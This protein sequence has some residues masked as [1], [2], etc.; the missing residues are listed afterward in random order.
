MYHSLFNH[1]HNERGNYYF[2]PL[3]GEDL[4]KIFTFHFTIKAQLQFLSPLQIDFPGSSLVKN[5][6]TSAGDARYTGLICASGRSPEEEM[7][8]HSS[9]LA[10][11]I[12]WTEEPGR[13]QSM[14]SPRVGYC[15]ATEHACMQL[16]C[17]RHC[18]HVSLCTQEGIP[19]GHTCGGMYAHPTHSAFLSWWRLQLCNVTKWG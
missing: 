10:W 4:W 1:S 19:L 11:R 7:A 17:R 16:G 6:P 9:I 18:V 2:F 12:P 14:G 15:W 13:Q 8:T 3:S 5:P